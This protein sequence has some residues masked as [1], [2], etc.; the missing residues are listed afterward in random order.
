ML[1]AVKLRE[2]LAKTSPVTLGLILVHALLLGA[3]LASARPTRAPW[4]PTSERP[5][6]SPPGRTLR[7]LQQLTADRGLA[8]YHG[9]PSGAFLIDWSQSQRIEENASLEGL[10]LFGGAAA[11]RAD[12]HLF[13]DD[14]LVTV[15]GTRSYAWRFTWDEAIDE[16]VRQHLPPRFLWLDPSGQ[17]VTEDTVEK[18]D[19]WP[20]LYPPSVMTSAH[21]VI[22]R[23]MV[24][25]ADTSRDGVKR[26]RAAERGI[27]IFD[28]RDGR[29]LAKFDTDPVRQM[30]QVPD[31][32][33][34]VWTDAGSCWL[35]YV[36]CDEAG[37][38]RLGTSELRATEP[39]LAASFRPS[40]ERLAVCS[41]RHVLFYEGQVDG[42]VR[43]LG[44]TP[45]SKPCRGLVLTSPQGAAVMLEDRSWIVTRMEPRP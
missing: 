33:G 4:L 6:V 21:L 27:M 7:D 28:L 35:K 22:V 10:E 24:E 8:V 3:R 2:L 20:G 42:A 44:R 36:T 34:F 31:W 13:L 11:R 14:R 17:A 23:P 32:P 25:R 5:I 39:I 12:D 9:D 29:P 45:I 37:R 41:T 30:F 18:P 26:T 16:V 43:F 38:C 19:D 1:A 15:T 40:D